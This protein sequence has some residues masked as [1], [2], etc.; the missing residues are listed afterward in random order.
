MRTSSLEKASHDFVGLNT[1]HFEERV[2]FLIVCFSRLC[3]LSHDI[4]VPS[5]PNILTDN[6]NEGDHFVSLLMCCVW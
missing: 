2:L 3:V 5:M 1:S 6:E 4:T